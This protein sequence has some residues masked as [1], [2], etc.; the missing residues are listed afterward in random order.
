[1]S[2]DPNAFPPPDP[3]FSRA[4]LAAGAPRVLN[5][6]RWANATVLLYQRS[7]K[8]WVV[9]DFR[10]CPFLY[11]HTFGRLMVRRELSALARLRGIP[12]V[13]AQAFRVDDFA[14]AYRFVPGEQ[15]A[16]VG[17]EGATPEYFQALERAVLAIHERGIA[18]LDLRYGGNI[19]VT[20]RGEPFVLD[21]Q[22]HVKLA[23]LPAWLKRVLVGADLSGLYKHWSHRHPDTLGPERLAFL[24][25]ASRLRKLWVFK[26]Y[27]GLKPHHRKKRNSADT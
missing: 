5:K 15:I 6:G 22:S 7:G 4:D 24:E 18:H 13:P 2:A 9:K 21:F 1:M 16:R 11:R 12:G 20:D 25:R 10:P 17:A 14:L 8:H 3:P 26:G 23:G 27:L 19:L